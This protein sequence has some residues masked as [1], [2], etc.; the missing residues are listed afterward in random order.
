MQG[1]SNNVFGGRT[2]YFTEDPDIKVVYC[3]VRKQDPI[4]TPEVGVTDPR[5]IDTV[6]MLFTSCYGEPSAKTCKPLTSQ[7]R[8]L[9]VSIY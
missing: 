1:N 9:P 2:V 7:T 6:E 4:D 8:C 3:L 5:F